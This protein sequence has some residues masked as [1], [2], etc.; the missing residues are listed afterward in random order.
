MGADVVFFQRP[1]PSANS[2]LIKDEKTIL[3][4][5]GFGSDIARTEQLIRQYEVEPS[6]LDLIINT[7]YHSD[8]V[9]GNHYFQKIYG[10]SIAAHKWEADLINY[11]DPEACSAEW[12]DQPV[13]PYRV[14]KILLDQDKINTGS[15]TFEVLH[16]PGHTLGHIS[17]YEPE[18]QLLICGDLF[19]YK[20]VGWLN[21]FR[22]GVN[23]LGRSIE[24]LDKLAQL[25][26]KIAYPGH[27]I[28]IDEPLAMIDMARTR[29]EKWIGQPEKIYWHAAKRIFSFSLIIRNGI[30][31]NA[32]E[33]YLM[34]CGWFHDFAR[35]AFHEQPKDFVKVLLDEMLRSGAARWQ[36][37][38]LTATAPYEIPD[39]YWSPENI[40][41]RDW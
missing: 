14:N 25:N 39:K 38:I 12:L 4:D 2:I 27:G 5:T 9:G 35:N 16:T 17:L 6:E 41:P 20:D 29:L 15:S 3:V 19:H 24:S 11:K 40:K 28:A 30:E 36:G 7:H 18:Q 10:T 31:K 33:D 1:F 37:D 26:I 22:E 34:E 13:E 8:H 32:I 21:I 23:S